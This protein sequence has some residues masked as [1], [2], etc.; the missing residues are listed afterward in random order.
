MT[1]KGDQSGEHPYLFYIRV[2]PPGHN[3]CPQLP[4]T[5]FRQQ[6]SVHI[7]PPQYL[8]HCASRMNKLKRE[9]SGDDGIPRALCFPQPPSGKKRPLLRTEHWSFIKNS[10]CMKN[11][12]LDKFRFTVAMGFAVN[13]NRVLVV[14][15][16]H[17][18]LKRQGRNLNLNRIRL[19]QKKN[20]R[21]LC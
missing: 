3:F 19:F 16:N 15:K 6:T 11:T 14:G 18:Y 20:E 17:F 10:V 8:I 13:I 1:P 4:S 9:R 7:V 5:N 21:K 2:P 12:Y